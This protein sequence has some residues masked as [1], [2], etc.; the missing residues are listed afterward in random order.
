MVKGKTIKRRS[1]TLKPS[2]AYLTFEK[3]IERSLNLVELQPYVNKILKSIEPDS[4]VKSCDMSLLHN[5]P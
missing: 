1:K 3:V 5:Y 4:N 2:K